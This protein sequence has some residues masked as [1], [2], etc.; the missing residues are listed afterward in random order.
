MWVG[1]G[2]VGC[3]TV[4]QKETVGITCGELKADF[5]VRALGESLVEGVTLVNGDPTNQIIGFGC[6]HNLS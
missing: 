2:G 6:S 5:T 3:G 4:V 1:V